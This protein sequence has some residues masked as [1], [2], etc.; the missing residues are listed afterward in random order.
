MTP[1]K[2]IQVDYTKQVLSD[3]RFAKFNSGTKLGPPVSIFPKEL[4]LDE[5]VDELNRREETR[6]VRLDQDIDQDGKQVV[7]AGRVSTL[8]V[9]EE[10]NENLT[11]LNDAA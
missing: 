8:G 9:L 4:V 11:A 7:S 1:G 2:K 5:M 6:R 10:T 3:E